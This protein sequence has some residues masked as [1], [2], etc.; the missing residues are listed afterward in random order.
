MRHSYLK[1]P[2]DADA[3]FPQAVRIVLG[4]TTYLT[5]YTVSVTDDALL[6]V[7]E[8]LELPRPGAYLVLHVAREDADGPRTLFR[9]KVVPDLEYEADELALVFTGITVHPLNL[10]AAGAHGSAVRGGVALLWGS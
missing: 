6:A 5:E 9:R 4:T 1:L 2:V 3:G 7:R 8:P 10:N